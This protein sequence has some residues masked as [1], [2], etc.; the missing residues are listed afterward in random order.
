MKV[1][2][3]VMHR[4]VSMGF[5]LLLSSCATAPQ[6]QLRLRKLDAALQAIQSAINK[7][8]ASLSVLAIR[9]KAVVYEHAFGY[10]QFFNIYTYT[11]IGIPAT[12]HTRYRIASVSKLVTAL[13]AMRLVELGKLELDKDIG[14]YLGY[15]LRNP[16]FPNEVITPRMLMNHTSSLRD[17]GGYF[18]KANIA[19][20]DVLLPGGALYGRGEMWASNA[21]PGAYFSYANLPWG[22]LATVMEKVSD[23]RFD[24]L[25]TRLVFEPLG[26]QGGYHPADFSPQVLSSVATIYR[27]RSEVQGKEIWNP[28]GPWIPQVDDYQN[29]KPEPRA[30]ASYTAG[31]NGTAFSPQGGAR[32]TVGELGTLMLMLLNEGQHQGR[33]FLSKATIDEMLSVQWRSNAQSGMASNGE[34]NYEGGQAIF[35]AWGLGVQHFT[36]KSGKSLGDRLVA[37]GGYT[38]SG[39]LGDAYGL[40][41][42]FVFNR[43]QKSGMIYLHSGTGFDPETNP[44][45]H[46]AMYRHEEEILDALYTYA[47]QQ[48]QPR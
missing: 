22:V 1:I 19:L 25:M 36:D 27:K 28:L 13:G 3:F 15:P 30:D 46:S 24:R 9:D 31:S 40:T 34:V 48:Q 47:L 33:R 23:E 45:Q 39:H 44:G 14:E 10:Q 16:H 6:Q 35:N 42:A 4:I 32:L 7:P 41:S 12:T 18:W 17:E 37:L 20:K 11:D 29:T 8:L 38:A 21:K 43:E 5:V 2:S 26:I